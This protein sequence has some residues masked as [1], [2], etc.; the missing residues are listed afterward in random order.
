MPPTDLIWDTFRTALLPPFVVAAAVFALI[1]WLGRGREAVVH[2]AAALALPAGFVAGN[3]F[4]AALP[5]IPG[6]AAWQ[7]IVLVLVGVQVVGWVALRPRLPA[8][9]AWL[10]RGL[11]AGAAGWLLTPADLRAEHAWVAAALAG[12]V[13]A[14]WAVTDA[15]A[16]RPDGALATLGLALALFGAGGVLIHA[17]TARFMDA[18][19]L[20]AAA[21][22]G[23]AAGAGRR[24]TGGAVPGAI[25]ALAGL[26][27][28]G[29]HETYSEVPA[30]SFLLPA[31]APLAPGLTLL[32]PLRERQGPWV[33]LLRLGL[34]LGP[35]VVAVALAAHA[36][37]LDFE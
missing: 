33:A 23:V 14:D 10:L 26:L 29:F 5:L 27:L 24:P 28:S 9:G 22:V 15:L 20:V 19:L 34:V 32:P 1:A 3:Y 21:L 31:V 11:A 36:E 12:L 16:R 35:V 8:W 2:A 18:A 7:W 25:V 13:L 6:P 4:R 37:P 17:H 30:V